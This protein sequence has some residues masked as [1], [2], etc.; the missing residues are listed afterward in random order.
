MPILTTDT[1]GSGTLHTIAT[2]NDV[3]LLR[4][5]VFFIGTG[6]LPTFSITGANPSLIVAGSIYN[7]GSGA[8]ILITAS[9]SITVE[10]EGVI[11]AESAN[12][13]RGSGGGQLSLTNHGTIQGTTLSAI[14]LSGSLT[15]GMRLAL[16][17]TGSISSVS[18]GSTLVLGDN[19]DNILNTGTILGSVSLGNGNNRIDT[20]LGRIGG[21][22]L[23]RR[24]H[25]EA[26]RQ[27]G[28]GRLCA[29]LWRL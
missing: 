15:T 17:N 11:V 16:N 24:R 25:G 14:S 22:H 6:S 20:H 19:G 21:R 26:E 7:T 27:R 23:Y 28:L 8:G 4:P 1:I 29:Q 3:T 12:A 18:G 9:T 13:I 2:A 10:A 5:D